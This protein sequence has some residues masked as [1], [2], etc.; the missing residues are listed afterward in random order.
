MPQIPLPILDQRS[1]LRADCS[2][3]AGLCCVAPAFAASADF[4]ID[5]PAG[6]ACPNLQEDF[7]CGIHAQLRER[8]FPGCT[9]FDC[10][11]AGQQITQNTFGGR[12]WRETPELAQAQFAVL[13]VMRQLHEVL[14][15]LTEAAEL[16]AAASLH[17]E[18]RTARERAELLSSG[19]A[20]ELLAF[21]VAA[22]RAEVGELL[23]RV[24]ETVRA[25][26]PRR[27]RD[28]RGADL[29]GKD[30]R[31]AQLRG[32]SL[33]G[34]Y[35]IGADLRGA[36]LGSADLLGADLRA[37]D[38]RD[39]DLSSALFLTQPQ[40]E[41]AKGNPATRIPA[42]LRRPRHWAARGTGAR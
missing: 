41:A 34:A 20:E 36:D 40:V 9:V 39:A 1:H 21:D 12:S 31:T 18:V 33:R 23:H 29:M 8:G 11:G 25:G 35:L 26:V 14:W 5:K 30:L 2:R 28:R 22:F 15:Y 17:D 10:F 42:A 24:S 37:A 19:S 32:A 6:H 27:A 16:R 3:C 7:R 4:A 38:L 13:P